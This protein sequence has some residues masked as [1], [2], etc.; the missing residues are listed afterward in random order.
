MKRIVI[1]LPFAIVLATGPAFAG[2][3]ECSAPKNQWQTQDTLRQ[4]LA[5]EGWSIRRIKVE[6]GCYEVYAMSAD[7]KR[8]E[9]SFNPATLAPVA[10][11]DD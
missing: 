2:N 1:A 11:G 9:K 3:K 5:S 8:I 4:K 7:G 10:D 6:D